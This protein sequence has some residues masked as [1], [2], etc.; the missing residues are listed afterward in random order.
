MARLAQ[1]WVE[2]NFSA[3]VAPIDTLE[4]D[5]SNG[6]K[7]LKILEDKRIISEEELQ[8]ASD[9]NLPKIVMK[10][11][12]I[13]TKALKSINIALSKQ[14]IADVCSSSSLWLSTHDPHADHLRAARWRG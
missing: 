13:L 1:N 3:A 11:M 10:N 9:G 5:F 12:A 4:K 7:F 6:Y 2:T 8:D 14:Q